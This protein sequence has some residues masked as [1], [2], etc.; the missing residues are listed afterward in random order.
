MTR[1][2][3]KFERGRNRVPIMMPIDA[4]MA[5]NSNLALILEHPIY[6]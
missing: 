5:A 2:R 6:I 1:D 4:K 3:Q